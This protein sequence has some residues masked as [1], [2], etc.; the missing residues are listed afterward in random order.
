ML[1]NFKAKASFDQVGTDLAILTSSGR[2]IGSGV[3]WQ[4]NMFYSHEP[5]KMF[6]SRSN[7]ERKMLCKH[8]KI[9]T[10]PPMV[11]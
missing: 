6:R 4:G 2:V 5:M 1:D 7:K 10:S 3:H 11:I 8:I 9:T